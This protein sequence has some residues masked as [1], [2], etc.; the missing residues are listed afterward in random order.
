MI[1]TRCKEEKPMMATPPLPTALG[2]KL[3]Q[4]VCASCWAD[5]KRS[6]LMVIN[7]YR[8]NMMDKEH[9]EFLTKQMKAFIAGETPQTNYTPE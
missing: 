5:W 7:E 9:R 6:E 8:L 3:Q 1:C 4:E 2:Q